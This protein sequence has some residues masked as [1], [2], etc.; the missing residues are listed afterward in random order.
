MFPL[1]RLLCLITGT[2]LLTACGLQKTLQPAA[3]AVSQPLPTL[4]EPLL[5]PAVT[6]TQVPPPT[7]PSR[8]PTVISPPSATPIPPTPLPPIP[9]PCAQLGQIHTG[10]FPSTIAGPQRD[11]RIYLPPCYGH[12]GRVFPTLYILHGNV[13]ADRHWDDLG[14]DEAAETAVQTGAIP[15]LIIV[16]PNG[17]GIGDTSSGGPWSY[18]GVIL[19]ELIPFIEST[20]CAWREPAGRAIGGLSRG[21]YW[22]L[23]IAFRHPDR[24]ASVGGH[25]AALLDQYAGP[26]LNP[27]YTGVNN[28]L[29]N[30]RIYLDFGAQDYLLYNTQRLHEEM[31]AAGV[32]HT[33]HLNEGGHDDA[34]WMA[35]LDDYL[36]WYSEPWP[37]ER[38]HYPECEVDA[39]SPSPPA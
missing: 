2:L 3:T 26:D 14:L 20:T 10:T 18:E 24:F 9:T 8:L 28:P 12:D 4:I 13:V 34:Y 27:Q 19:N 6:A 38:T 37:L 29:G 25:S 22:A 5:F 30:L 17:A 11:Y 1:I 36:A 31:T 16:M 23:E 7:L 35:H 21:G 33:W 39:E 15:P 32:A